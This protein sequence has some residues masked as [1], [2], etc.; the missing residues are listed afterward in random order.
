VALL[1]PVDAR[2][3]PVP[4]NDA[5]RLLFRQLYETPVR[6]DCLGNVRPSLARSWHSTGDTLWT[7]QLR[8]GAR[9]WDGT[10]VDADAVSRAWSGTGSDV[11]RS[12]RAVAGSAIEVSLAAPRP[13]QTFGDPAWSVVKRITVSP[14]PLGTAPVWARDWE[15]DGRDS[16]LRAIPLRDAPASTPVLLFRHGSGS[17]PRDFIDSGADVLPTREG[18]VL[19]YA[20]ARPGWRVV[21]L[22]WDRLY[23]LLSPARV[24]ATVTAELDADTRAAFARDAVREEARP[25]EAPPDGREWWE[26]AGCDVATPGGTDAGVAEQVR[27]AFSRDDPVARDLA[28]RLVARADV[29]LALLVGDLPASRPRAAPLGLTTYRAQLAAGAGLAFVAALPLRPL[30]HC[31]AIADLLASAPW[32]AGTSGAVA[33]GAVAPLVETRGY[34]LLRTGIAARL[35]GDGGARLVPEWLP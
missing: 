9:F 34:L 14:W 25:A 8:P 4:I 15:A 19:R 23:A 35:D 16:V 18:G 28:A 2:H 10:P 26:T 5:E 17:D 3:A 32:L 6:V 7:F 29:E 22:V 27:V 20:A 13:I 11:V 31:R 21:P 33:H 1:D 12:V 30:D 24:S